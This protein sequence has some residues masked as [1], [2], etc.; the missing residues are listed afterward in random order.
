MEVRVYFP[1]EFRNFVL[2]VEDAKAS[3]VWDEVRTC[4]SS[5][6]TIT[7]HGESSGGLPVNIVIPA[8]A[9]STAMFV[10]KE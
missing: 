1:E 2:N 6:A 4:L 8:A 9:A 10:F 7:M 3:A 5:G